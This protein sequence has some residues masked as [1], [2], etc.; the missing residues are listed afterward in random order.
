MISQ[1][2]LKELNTIMAEDYGNRLEPKELADFGESILGYF[3]CLGEI[4]AE[5]RQI[6]K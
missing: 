6:N 2:L 3:E 4:E 5:I 1:L